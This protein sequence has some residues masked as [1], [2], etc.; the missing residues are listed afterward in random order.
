MTG[1]PLRTHNSYAAEGAIPPLKGPASKARPLGTEAGGE[2]DHVGG[3]RTGDGRRGVPA[4]AG[5]PEITERV[6]AAGHRPPGGHLG[7]WRR[8]GPTV[9]DCSLF[10]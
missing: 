8:K 9:S 5:R 1:S 10:P 3:Q 4:A 6:V 7:L 2:V